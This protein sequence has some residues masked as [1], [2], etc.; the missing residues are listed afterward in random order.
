[1]PLRR[2]RAP[3]SPPAAAWRLAREGCGEDRRWA[4]PGRF[5]IPVAVAGRV[6]GTG[7]PSDGP[8]GAGSIGLHTWSQRVDEIRDSAERS[9]GHR[10]F[11]RYGVDRGIGK[12]PC[13]RRAAAKGQT[14]RVCDRPVRTRAFSDCSESEKALQVFA[15]S[16]F[17]TGKQGPSPNGTESQR[18]RVPTGLRSNGT[19]FQRDRVPTRLGRCAPENALASRG[20]GAQRQAACRMPCPAWKAETSGSARAGRTVRGCG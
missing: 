19:A 4:K 8:F 18:D 2:F 15:L 1:M 3:S 20:G 16:R 14:P 9:P 11:G 7:L 6:P 5:S 10:R 13:S 17:R 12:S